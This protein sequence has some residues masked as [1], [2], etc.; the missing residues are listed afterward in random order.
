MGLIRVGL[1]PDEWYPVYSIDRYDV[2]GEEFKAGDDF[3]SMVPEDLVDR[4]ESCMKEFDLIQDELRRV[5]NA[6]R[7]NTDG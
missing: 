7:G 3:A 2:N 5:Y 6:E 1:Y 4:F